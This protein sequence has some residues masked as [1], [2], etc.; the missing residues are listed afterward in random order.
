MNKI[1]AIIPARG[2]SK[3]I[4]KK[5]I[6]NLSG[7]PLIAYSI[8]AAKLTKSI[9][10]IIVSTDDQKIAQVAKKYGAE[11]PFL[12]PK[13]FARDNSPD[14]E[15]ML[16][17]IEWMKKKEGFIAP[18]LVLLRPTTPFRNPQ[19]IEKAIQKI[20]DHPKATSLCSAEK[21]DISPYK[22]VKLK[23]DFFYD[24]SL[25][26]S[27]PESFNLPRQTFPDVYFPNGYIDIIK[28]KSIIKTGTLYGKKILA[29]ITDP[30]DDIDTPDHLQNIRNNFN[31]KSAVYQF[32]KQN[33]NFIT[34]NEK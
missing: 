3:S 5:N 14:T 7:Y 8:A 24:L 18:Y 16:H 13:K 31:K 30:V 11:M 34:S 19:Q 20:M 17:V 2:G 29:F 4:P 28:S 26:N 25:N 33:F 6:V 27:Q 21:I 23:N 10:R 12:R 15:F 22:C 32:L 9:E 1:I